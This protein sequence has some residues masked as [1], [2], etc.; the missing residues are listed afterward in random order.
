VRF[1]NIKRLPSLATLTVLFFFL[2]S[3]GGG[4][5][6]GGSGDNTPSAPAPLISF[7]AD[8]TA[9]L[10]G[11]SS[12]LTWSS[13]NT[14]SCTGSGA[15]SGSKSLSGNQEVTIGTPGVNTFTLSCSGNGGTSSK[16]VDVE[17]Y[18]LFKGKSVDGYIRGADIWIDTDNNFE[19]NENRFT[20]SDNNGEFEIRFETGN[21]LSLGGYDLDTNNLLDNFMLSHPLDEYTETKV[22]TPITSLMLGF[23]DDTKIISSLGIDDSINFQINDPVSLKGDNGV[24]DYYYEKGNQLTVLSLVIQNIVN[25]INSSTESS[26]DYFKA[27]A[28]ELEKEFTSTS[29]AVNIESKDFIVN[30]IDNIIS[31]K[32]LSI[33]DENK[34]NLS[35]ILSSTL[36]ILQVKETDSDTVGLFNFFLTTLIT[37]SISASKGEISSNKL[38][39]YIND[40]LLLISSDQGLNIIN[41]TPAITAFDDQ[42]TLDED[43]TS[44]INILTNDDYI[45]SSPISVSIESP[46]NGLASI[47]NGVVTYTPEDDFNGTDNISYTLTQNTRS[48]TANINITVNPINDPPSID[49]PSTLSVS[50]GVT[51]VATIEVS[52]I[53][54]DE[55]LTLSLTGTD[56]DSFSL[57][58]ERVLSFKEAPVYSEKNEYNITLELSDGNLSVSKDI[59][60]LIK[61]P[62][63]APQISGNLISEDENIINLENLTLSDPETDQL[64]VSIEPNVNWSGNTPI[65]TVDDLD[66]LETVILGN[67]DGSPL[68]ITSDL[69]YA[70]GQVV[71]LISDIQL[72]DGVQLWLNNSGGIYS[73]KSSS[74]PKIEVRG[75]K[76]R[77]NN[78][79]MRKVEISFIEGN[80]ATTGDITLIGCSWIK[81][82]FARAS[83][84]AVYGS[85]N[86]SQNYLEEINQGSY[87]YLWYPRGFYFYK[88]IFYN[89]GAFNVLFRSEDI[90][91]G[92]GSS[93]FTGNIF[94]N[95]DNLYPSAGSCP[96]KV[97]ICLSAGY[98]SRQL[99][100]INNVFLNTNIQAFVD[101]S[102]SNEFEITSDGDYFGI[103]D[104]NNVS[105]R[106]LDN[107][108]NLSYN[109]IKIRD[110]LSSITNSSLINSFQPRLIYD[111]D[112]TFSFDVAPDYEALQ[113]NYY[114]KI[115][116]SD[117]EFTKSEE[118]TIQ[119]NN[120]TD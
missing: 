30:V 120:V 100:S 60:I 79:A 90:I 35:S 4:G 76:F 78:S 91:N 50:E 95:N 115:T 67:E 47:N 110:P 12:T 89:S 105:S 116:F 42:L 114:Y 16:S 13:S 28:E 10:L 53:D 29:T 92:T 69:T 62:N 107:T 109:A 58:S 106:Y 70:G 74:F 21:L 111:G 112:Y 61:N 94:V 15:W 84:N 101:N 51:E 72:A 117:D 63:T 24:G 97:Y 66:N 9:V 65:G 36:P 6:G 2:S 8:P 85:I 49:T 113:R 14:T 43:T 39:Q 83:G 45:S 40:T 64:S 26:Q 19:K 33:S 20:S 3:C 99:A 71:K 102:G 5:G 56:A 41:I 57:S 55:D 18:R 25:N 81:G 48:S 77:C 37:D 108:D 73:D 93:N 103:T 27:I 118:V 54:G 32:S 87:A 38:E 11:N 80:T 98:G 119:I 75:G 46:Q 82:I 86:L 104:T 22:I 34:D 68:I 1:K 96:F 52:D 88:N 23:E 59:K 17:G 31:T 44:T 7:S